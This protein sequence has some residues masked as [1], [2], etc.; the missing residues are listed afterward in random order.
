MI[1]TPGPRSKLLLIAAISTLV[2][3]ILAGAQQTTSTTTNGALAVTAP[4]ASGMSAARLA[5]LTSAFKKE[6]EDKKLPGAVMLVTRKGK[7][8][9]ASALGARDPK[10]ADAMRLDTIFRIYSMTKPMASVATMILFEDGALQLT[11]PVSKWLPAFK[12]VKVS[13]SSGDVAA[14]RPMTVQDLLR[15]TAGLPYGELTQ[16]AA[17]KEALAQAG[18]YKPGVID[19]DIR[20]MTGAEQVRRLRGPLIHQPGMTRG[21]SPRPTS[22]GAWWALPRAS[23]LVTS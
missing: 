3:P 4:E 22:S 18:L 7:V 1:S 15:H 21:R 10:R 14:Q 2:W 17:V 5:R 11:D 20:D 13:T 19:F 16:N 23:A 8:V 6:I 9:Y 12:D